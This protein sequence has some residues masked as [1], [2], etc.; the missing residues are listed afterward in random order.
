M[1]CKQPREVCGF[2][3]DGECSG[4]IDYP[5]YGVSEDYTTPLEVDFLAV[6][7][8]RGMPRCIANI[9]HPKPSEEEMTHRI[10]EINGE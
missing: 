2:R 6:S 8:I 3:I 5:L 1:R 9:L 7:I 10:A 4:R